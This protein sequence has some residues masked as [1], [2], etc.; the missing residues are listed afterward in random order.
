MHTGTYD[1]GKARTNT[2][3]RNGRISLQCNHGRLIDILDVVIRG[4]HTILKQNAEKMERTLKQ[5]CNS[6]RW[7]NML[8]HVPAGGSFTID[9]DCRRGKIIPTILIVVMKSKSKGLVGMK[10]NSYNT[11]P[12]S[13]QLHF[14]KPFYKTCPR[15]N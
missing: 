7:C 2:L 14:I 3:D 9:Y 6:D 4:N 11:S 8:G 10:A 5:Q 15:L 1:R 12:F 13:C